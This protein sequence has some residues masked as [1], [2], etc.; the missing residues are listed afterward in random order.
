MPFTL[1][2]AVLAPPIAKLTGYRLPIAALAIGTM[3]PDLYRLFTQ[4]DYDIS[5]QWS[6]IIFPNLLI[7]LVFCLLWYG[8]YRTAIFRFFGIKKPLNLISLDKI[9]GF[10]IAIIFA[11]LIGIST[12]LVWDGLTHSDFRSFA[13][14]DFLNQ[15]VSLGKYVYPMHRV[16]QIGTSIIALPFLI[17]MGIHY[18]FKF[19]QATPIPTKIK[20]YAFSLFFITFL[21][22]I[23][24]YL[25]FAQNIQNDPLA[26]DL[27]WYIG[28]SINQFASASLIT[29][30]LG[31]LIFLILDRK[32]LFDQHR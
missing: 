9:A 26:T 21:S 7:G 13:F 11:V 25:N 19:R 32:Y 28:K 18:Y 24:S 17:W 16:L 23:F 12:H 14:E 1:S 27:Y 15:S 10:L 3:T 22:G 4:A 30:S 6:G 2:H 20:T 8:L 29:F 5:H 31:C